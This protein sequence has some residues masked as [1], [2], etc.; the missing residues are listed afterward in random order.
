M[1]PTADDLRISMK[2]MDQF[3]LRCFNTL[4]HDREISGVQIANSLLQ[5]PDHYTGNDN[6]V[7]VNL[8]WLR[9]HVHT[10]IKPTA[11]PVNDSS[12]PLDDEQCVYQAGDK[13]P[14]SRMDNYRY[15]G[16]S[17]LISLSSNTTCWCSP[18]GNRIPSSPT[19]NLTLHTQGVIGI[20][21]IWPRRSLKF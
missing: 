3:A 9:H 11:P 6:F 21:N 4:S 7:Q 10:T 19:S 5:L 13:V 18:R 8:W 20:Y 1:D 17:C 12:N 16:H 15:R 14:S 2:D